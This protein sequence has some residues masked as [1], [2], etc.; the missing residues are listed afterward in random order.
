MSTL[1]PIHE[2][3]CPWLPLLF[4][5]SSTRCHLL[6]PL[7]TLL[8]GVPFTVWRLDSNRTYLVWSDS[9]WYSR[10]VASVP[11]TLNNLL[12]GPSA[13]TF[14]TSAQKIWFGLSF[15]LKHICPIIK[16][17]TFLT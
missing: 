12:D 11:W 4:P 3:N 6:S 16:V 15:L 1:F 7:D 10:T 8:A 14:P 13:L 5:Y 17:L 9:A 2:A